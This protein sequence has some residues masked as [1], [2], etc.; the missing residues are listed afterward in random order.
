[1][2]IGVVFALLCLKMRLGFGALDLLALINALFQ[3]R[4]LPMAEASLMMQLPSGEG[5]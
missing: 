1:M 5:P 2:S 3:R 4:E